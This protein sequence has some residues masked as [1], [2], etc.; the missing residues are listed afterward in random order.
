MSI[1][2]KGHA[3]TLPIAYSRLLMAL[4]TERGVSPDGLLDGTG[5]SLHQFEQPD[6]RLTL[7][8]LVRL[9]HNALTLTGEPGLG[10]DYGLSIPVTAHGFL[11]YAVMSCA[12]LR[13]ALA[14]GQQFLSLRS[15][16]RI[17]TFEEAEQGV[18]ELVETVSLGPLRRFALDCAVVT[19]ARVGQTITAMGF[20]QMELWFDFPESPYFVQ[21]RSR[22]PSAHFDRPAIQLRFRRELLDRPPGDGGHACDPIGSG[23]MRAGAGPLWKVPECASQSG[24]HSRVSGHSR[25]RRRGG[26]TP[27]VITD[28]QASVTAGGL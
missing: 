2:R 10:Y 28:F 21:Y 22:L 18:V 19:L 24:G 14:L 11:G 23:S 27:L 4:V 15:T 20:E 12:T 7:I 25:L 6:A 16:L 13:D 9:F 26:A 5:L 1:A 8:Q 3:P 17:R